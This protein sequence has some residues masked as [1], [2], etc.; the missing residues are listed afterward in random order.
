M[1]PNVS[2]VIVGYKRPNELKVTLESF[3]DKIDYPREKLEIIYCDDGSPSKDLTIIKKLPI[4]KFLIA[5]KNQGIGAN[6]NK[7][8]KIASSDY[9][10]QLQDDF[11]Y[12]GNSQI[13][14]DSIAIL[15]E[16]PEIGMI[17]FKHSSLAHNKK[18]SKN[19]LNLKIFDNIYTKNAIAGD[20]PYTD[21]PH[22]KKSSFQRVIGLYSE[23][24]PMH[25]TELDFCERVA[26]NNI[27][28]IA[29]IEKNFEFMHIGIN[30]SFNP[31]R[32]KQKIARLLERTPIINFIFDKYRK[33]KRRKKD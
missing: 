21:T 24:L 14:K 23:N 32:K 7:G 17:R 6:T 4:D 16:F 26:K 1:E 3:L 25:K 22:I 19:G 9:I 10:F 18:I 12:I 13:I 5:K 33:I 8:L 30:K 15:N 31:T 27:Y 20:Y 29:Q 11:K 2:V 28:N